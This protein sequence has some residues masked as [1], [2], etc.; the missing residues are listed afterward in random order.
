[1]RKIVVRRTYSVIDNV[2]VKVV[3]YISSPYDELGREFETEDIQ[4]ARV[5]SVDDYYLIR[6]TDNI[7]VKVPHNDRI[8]QYYQD[9]YDI[10]DLDT[11]VAAYQGD[12]DY[13]YDNRIMLRYYPKMVIERAPLC[14]S[15]LELG[16]GHGY[17]TDIFSKNYQRHLVIEGSGA[18][19]DNFKKNYPDCRAQIQK[20]M[21]EEF[22][23]DEKFGVIVLG[24]VL[25]HVDDPRLILKKYQK[26]LAEKG[27]MFVAVPNYEALNRRVGYEAGMIESMD[28]MSEND[29]VLGHK[30]FYNLSSLS[31]DINEAGLHSCGSA[32]IFLKPFS[33]KQMI[34]LGLDNK[35]IDGFCKVGEM[36]PEL[37]CGILTQVY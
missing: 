1:M 7:N 33:T 17:T 19:I 36:F 37:C 26:F 32:G 10:L 4:N 21:F 28:E 35:I 11:H 25:E 16:L 23:T 15:C 20:C 13:E 14:Y 22:D 8:T 34:S 24:F 5:F 27:K 31:L 30:R 12:T 29:R 9:H 6:Y 18:V 3:R 2:P